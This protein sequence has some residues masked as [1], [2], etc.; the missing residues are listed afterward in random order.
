MREERRLHAGQA[1]HA[2]KLGMVAQLHEVVRRRRGGSGKAVR[3]PRAARN[4]HAAGLAV[5]RLKNAAL[6]QDHARKARQIEV[7]HLGVVGNGDARLDL[8]LAGALLGS[9]AELA[10][11]A[12]H[13]AGNGQRRKQ[14]HVAPGRVVDTLAPCQLHQRLAKPGLGKDR[15]PAPTQRPAHDVA[16]VRKE[17]VRQFG[18][19]GKARRRVGQRLAGEEG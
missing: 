15:R 19:I 4:Q 1:H 16:L 5:K 7:M 13:L 3:H 6:V 2:Q 11:L 8:G 12:H 14:K 9:Q 10:R 18:D 17:H